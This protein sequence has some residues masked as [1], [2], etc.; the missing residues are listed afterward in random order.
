MTTLKVMKCPLE[1]LVEDNSIYVHSN[2]VHA[3][4][5]IL[6]GRSFQIK[7]HQSVRPGFVALNFMQRKDLQIQLGT[8]IVIP[9]PS[10]EAN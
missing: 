6:G 3:E 2:Q 9:F 7:E 5:V 8:K 10:E 1:S 4:Y